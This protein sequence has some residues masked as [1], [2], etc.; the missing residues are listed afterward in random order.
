[1]TLVARPIPPTPPQST[2]GHP[3]PEEPY[4][5]PGVYRPVGIDM[6][7]PRHRINSGQEM[8]SSLSS[9]CYPIAMLT[10]LALRFSSV[11]HHPQFFSQ[12][13]FSI[14]KFDSHVVICPRVRLTKLDYDAWCP[15]YH[16][17]SSV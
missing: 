14:G 10:I 8:V 12:H 9:G 6:Q 4:Q 16:A 11:L 13:A 5:G 1:M 2:D 7:V 15:G 17:S 3:L